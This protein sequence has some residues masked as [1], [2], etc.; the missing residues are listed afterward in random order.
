M[1]V[2]CANS[3]NFYGL[4]EL[5][6]QP[7]AKFSNKEMMMNTARE[8][9][10][11]PK[12]TL[13]FDPNTNGEIFNNYPSQLGSPLGIPTSSGGAPSRGS[14]NL[15]QPTSAVNKFPS[16]SSTLPL[17]PSSGFPSAPSGVL[18]QRGANGGTVYVNSLGQLST[19]DDSGFDPKR[20]FILR[21]DKDSTF[22]QDIRI[23]SN[24][25]DTIKGIG[26]S[27]SFGFPGN[28][29]API[30]GS[31]DLSEPVDPSEYLNRNDQYLP[32][33]NR[34]QIYTYP[35]DAQ[36]QG[37]N[38]IQAILPE[39]TG[40]LNTKLAAQS[41]YQAYQAPQVYGPAATQTQAAPQPRYQQPPTQTRQQQTP[42]VQPPQTFQPG[43]NTQS[44][45]QPVQPQSQP[46]QPQLQPK[47]QPQ[48]SYQQPQKAQ[49]VPQQLYQQ[50]HQHHSHSQTPQQQQPHQHQAQTPQKQ[51]TPQKPVNQ[52]YQQPHQT[53]KQQQV[54][55][56]PSPYQP[57][58]QQ[59]QAR[60]A[61]QQP[62]PTQLYQQPQ[63][64]PSV[65]LPRPFKPQQ[66]QQIE[67]RQYNVPQSNNNQY[68]QQQPQYNQ[69]QPQYNQQQQV[70]PG[71][72]GN[73]QND[74]E[75]LRNILK[76]KT[77]IHHDKVQL[78][79][80]IQR[81]FEPPH[82]KTRV[83]SAEVQESQGHSFSFTDD[84]DQVSTS[85]LNTHSNY[86]PGHHQHTGTCGHQGY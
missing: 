14:L 57:A 46:I 47:Q 52:L 82:T 60:P 70:R 45:F 29:N 59:S 75:F 5:I 20:S 54:Q 71:T 84:D 12:Q 79:D 80:L 64:Q 35:H 34:K 66:Q 11:F 86:Q 72:N 65:E 44:R 76:N 62:Q 61:Q 27:Y 85:N 41:P 69:Q 23:P 1:N 19:D 13:N 7:M 40:Q 31:A 56:Q 25:F 30:R 21:T 2:N 4:N 68:N 77:Y 18:P 50:P 48:Q 36:S 37:P 22:D 55:Q 24:S 49:V 28:N 38:N 39:Y 73:A 9:I 83:L 8:I 15:G 16:S 51:P 67:R 43:P 58:Q 3:E 81:L 6:G 63:Q 17:S 78:V 32:P 33:Q 53:I 42:Q 26:N 10:M 74:N